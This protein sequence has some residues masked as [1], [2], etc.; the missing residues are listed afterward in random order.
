MMTEGISSSSLIGRD[1]TT[2]AAQSLISIDAKLPQY[3][4]RT[5]QMMIPVVVKNNSPETRKVTMDVIVP[6]R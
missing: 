1:E 5:D 4:T 3:L 6:N 2:Y